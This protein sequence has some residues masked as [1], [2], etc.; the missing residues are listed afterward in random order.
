MQLLAH[1]NKK[2]NGSFRIFWGVDEMKTDFFAW[3]SDLP[4]LK[5]KI[6]RLPKNLGDYYEDAF[7]IGYDSIKKLFAS[8]QGISGAMFPNDAY[9]IGAAQYLLENRINEFTLVGFNGDRALL[10]FPYPV[11][12]GI[13]P[14]GMIVEEIAGFFKNDTPLQKLLPVELILK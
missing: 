8:T 9:A 14:I 1:L 2:T 12:T 3:R 11:S 13:Q 5:E 7:N 6:I 4:G 10:R